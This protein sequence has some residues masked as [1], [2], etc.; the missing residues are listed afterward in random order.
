MQSNFEK[1]HKEGENNWKTFIKY[2][3]NI[4]FEMDIETKA[5]GSQD[6]SSPARKR[7]SLSKMFRF[8]GLSGYSEA[9]I[10]TEK[11]KIGKTNTL[12]R[13]LSKKQQ[14]GDEEKSKA[15]SEKRNSFL[16]RSLGS[17][18]PWLSRKV[19]QMSIHGPSSA[20]K[21][22]DIPSPVPEASTSSQDI[23]DQVHEVVIT[24]L[25]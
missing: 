3:A 13:F 5:V 16:M 19:S 23:S 17:T 1:A 24:P 9:T 2:Y 21:S 12:M 8:K 22:V 6:E 15:H 4:L 10:E 7:S 25:E 11:P 14:N 20:S 18:V